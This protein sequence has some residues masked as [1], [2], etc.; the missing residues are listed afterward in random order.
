MG[1][2]HTGIGAPW[3]CHILPYIEQDAFTRTTK[4]SKANAAIPLTVGNAYYDTIAPVGNTHLQAMDCPS[5]P[6]NNE[7]LN[8]GTDMEHL[9][10]GNYAACYGKGGYG[11]VNYQNGAIGGLF[12]NNSATKVVTVTDGLSNTLCLSELKYRTPSGTGPSFEDSRGVWAYGTMGGNVFSSQTGP[13]SGTND[14]VWGCRNFPA[15]G[16]P[17]SQG[18]SPFVAN[19]AAARSYHTGGVNV[20]LGDG[21]VRF[22]SNSIVL[23]T[24][25]ALGSRAGGEAVGSID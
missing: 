9:A 18:G 23:S 7:Q 13:N 14:L 6:W 8:N 10:R 1:T 21:S 3:I 17:C 12:G 22:V 15:E 25:Q 4:E 16:M 11:T 19:Y 20:S 24:W 5:H 2:T